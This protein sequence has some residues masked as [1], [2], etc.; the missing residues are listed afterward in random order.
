MKAIT[1]K[2]LVALVALA[3]TVTLAYAGM[4]NED[5]VSWNAHPALDELSIAYSTVN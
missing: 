3:I 1:K 4:H 2:V 5:K